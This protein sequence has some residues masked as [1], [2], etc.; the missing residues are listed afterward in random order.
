MRTHIGAIITDFFCQ[1]L[2]N[3]AGLSENTLNHPALKV[4]GLCRD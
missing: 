2:T 1:Y 4:Q 3:E